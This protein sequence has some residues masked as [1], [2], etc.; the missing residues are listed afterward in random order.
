MRPRVQVPARTKNLILLNANKGTYLLHVWIS[1][2]MGSVH[3]GIKPRT[4]TLDF[5]IGK[6]VFV[7][8]ERALN[9]N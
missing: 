7:L 1:S 2:L 8:L 6:K 9:D 3:S 4:E 5:Q